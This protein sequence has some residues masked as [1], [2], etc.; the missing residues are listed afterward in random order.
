MIVCVGLVLWLVCGSLIN[1]NTLP[2]DV[3]QKLET[4]ENVCGT[5][6]IRQDGNSIEIKV[7]D[8]WINLDDVSFIGDLSKNIYLEYD[9]NKIFVGHSGIYNTIK[10]LKSVGLIE[11]E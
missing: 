1:L 9:G 7:N 8:S 11:F 10:T 4:V 2:K 5:A 3:K 6:Y